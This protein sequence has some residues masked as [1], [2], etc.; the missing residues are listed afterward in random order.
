MSAFNDA[1]ADY[2]KLKAAFKSGSLK[3]CGLLLAK[4]K[5]GARQGSAAPERASERGCYRMLVGWNR[6]STLGLPH[7]LCPF[8]YS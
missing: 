4:L 5:V 6:Q 7:P 1:K 2:D 3:E 8:R